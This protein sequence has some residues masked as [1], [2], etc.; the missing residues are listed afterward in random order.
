MRRFLVGIAPFVA[1]TVIYFVV[2]WLF[3]Y[4][5]NDDAGYSTRTDRPVVTTW[6]TVEPVVGWSALPTLVEVR[7]VADVLAHDAWLAEQAALQQ[8]AARREAEAQ[9]LAEQPRLPSQPS[10]SVAEFLA[11][12]R[13]HESDSAGGY[14]AVSPSGTYRG[15]YQFHQNTWNTVAG[16]IRPDLIG[17]RPDQASPADQDQ[18][19][20]ELYRRQGNAPWGGRC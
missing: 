18:L 8:E 7:W 16:W 2:V 5:G 15:A 9:R 3:D 14:R 12:T 6:R 11:C 4:R 13:R 10:T 19:A 17:V 20:A 1:V